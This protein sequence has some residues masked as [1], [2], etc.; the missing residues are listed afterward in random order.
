MIRRPPRSTHCISSAASDVY[1][2]QVVIGGIE[3]PF[4]NN[5]SAPS[6]LQPPSGTFDSAR[7]VVTPVDSPGPPPDLWLVGPNDGPVGGLKAA[8]VMTIVD[9]AVATANKT[10]AVIRLP[11]GS[12]THMMIA[13]ADLDGTIIGLFRMH[14]ATI[15]SIDVAASKARN[16]IYFSGPNRTTADLP[17]VPMGTAVTNRTISFA[18]QPFYPPGIDGTSPGPFFNLF[19]QDTANPCTEGAHVSSSNQGAHSNQSGIVFFPGSVPLYVNG[20]LVGG[21]GVSGD[22]VDQDDFVTAGGMVGFEAP[23]NIRADQVL[24]QGIRLPYLKFPRN[25]TD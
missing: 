20:Q 11:I 12:R 17:G 25:P 13:V 23:S 5:T 6:D 19:L 10:R 18:A 3:L 14:D 7:Y 1:K 2:R 15:F 9:N 16:V 22:G 21:L 8:D 4:V 24:D